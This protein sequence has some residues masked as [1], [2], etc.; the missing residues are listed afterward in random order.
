LKAKV[1]VI[2]TISV[3]FGMY[4]SAAKSAIKHPISITPFTGGP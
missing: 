4:D 1:S 3:T 2:T